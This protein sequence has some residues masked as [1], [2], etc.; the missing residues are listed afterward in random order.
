LPEYLAHILFFLKWQT[1][2]LAK[3]LNDETDVDAWRFY[4]I[5]NRHITW[6]RKF[7]FVAGAIW[8]SAL[9]AYFAGLLMR[10]WGNIWSKCVKES[11]S[12]KAEQQQRTQDAT[13][14]PS[15]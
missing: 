12:E 2:C 10:W 13:V 7:G 11:L 6:C 1:F 3:N 14:K 15:V 8:K 4:G 9:A 5:W